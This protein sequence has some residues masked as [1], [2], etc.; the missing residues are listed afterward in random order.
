MRGSQARK[1]A[2]RG[3]G[4]GDGGGARHRDSRPERRAQRRH[5]AYQSHTAPC[6]G[7]NVKWQRDRGGSGHSKP[8]QGTVTLWPLGV[9]VPLGL[10]GPTLDT[11]M[12]REALWGMNG[13]A[14]GLP[15]QTRRYWVLTGTSGLLGVSHL[16]TLVA[17][18]EASGLPW[19]ASLPQ[20][21]PPSPPRTSPLPRRCAGGGDTSRGSRCLPWRKGPQT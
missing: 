6:W 19:S 12:L 18:I 20:G 21:P 11:S 5:M 9:L 8:N 2:G 14:W 16:S 7:E 10:W 17:L 4:V 3:G 1:A 15:P 13:L